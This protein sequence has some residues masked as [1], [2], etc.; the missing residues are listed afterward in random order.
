MIVVSVREDWLMQGCQSATFC[1]P[2]KAPAFLSIHQ[3]EITDPAPSQTASQA[4][5]ASRRAGSQADWQAAG[6][7]RTGLSLCTGWSKLDSPNWMVQVGWSKLDCPSWTVQI[8]WSKL[9]GSNSMAN[10]GESKL[11]RPSWMVQL[12]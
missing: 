5:Q 4:A 2:A 7:P 8:G 12:G 11:D 6:Q 3:H 1:M 10:I 9:G